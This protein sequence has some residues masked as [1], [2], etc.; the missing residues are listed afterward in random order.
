MEK[1]QYDELKKIQN[2]H[3]WFTGKHH[4]VMDMYET[5]CETN[6]QDKIFDVGCGMGITLT[7]LHQ[8]GEVYGMDFESDAVEY[9]QMLFDQDYSE[10]HIK[11]GSLP[12]NIPFQE[13]FNTIVALDVLE[14]IEDDVAALSELFKHTKVGGNLLLTVPALM[15]MWSGNDVLNHHYRRYEYEELKEKI[16]DAG[17]E[18]KKISY[19]NSY[20]FLPAYLVRKIKNILK[21]TSSDANINAKDSWINRLLG[22]IF[23]SETRKLKKGNFKIGVSLIVIAQKTL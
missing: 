20:L 6:A 18:I 16:E 23:R 3:W 5:F 8:K 11:V 10:E 12:Y 21:I 4:I 15:S 22:Y 19:Y 1:S 2:T 9:C 13:E 7:A 14:H 17:Y